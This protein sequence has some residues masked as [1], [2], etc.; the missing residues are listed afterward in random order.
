[1]PIEGILSQLYKQL[2]NFFYLDDQDKE[3]I[4]CVFESVMHKCEIN[5]IQSSNKYFVKKNEFYKDE[6]FFNPY[7]SVQYMVF[8]YY[9]AH[10]LYLNSKS[11][12]LCDRVYYLNKIMN[13][14]D[15]FYAIELPLH[16]GAEHPVGAVLGRANYGNAFFFYQ[17]CTVGG[18]YVNGELFYPVIGE[19]VSL[20]ANSSVIGKSIIGNNVKIG[21]GTIVKNQDVPHNCIVFGESPNL[22]IKRLIL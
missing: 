14:V 3:D 2:E 1:M 6:A 21:A 10:E 17:C 20:F 12:L 4:S 13:G 7:H 11:L 8:L 16:F 18:A 19:N 22:I 15:L 9:L 5:Y